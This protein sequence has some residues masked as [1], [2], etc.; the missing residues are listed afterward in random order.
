M[1]AAA[2]VVSRNSTTIWRVLHWVPIAF[3]KLQ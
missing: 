1:R 2:V 3:L